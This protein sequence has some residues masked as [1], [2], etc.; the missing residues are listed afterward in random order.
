MLLPDMPLPP[1]LDERD[2]PRE[3]PLLRCTGVSKRYSNGTLA[4]KEVDLR[5]GQREFISLLGP[6]GC[7]KSTLLKLIAGLGQVSAGEIDWP[8]SAYDVHGTAR[9][10]LSFVFQ[11]PTLL[12][13]ST[14]LRNVALPL[15][16]AGVG[17]EEREARSAAALASGGLAGF[18][19]AF[20]RGLSGGM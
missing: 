10:D 12:P 7:G 19:R 9:P 3:K 18:E 2:A 5:V 6:S 8:T 4:L 20:P 15:K 14:A 11:E 17:K 1:A 16:L 13:W